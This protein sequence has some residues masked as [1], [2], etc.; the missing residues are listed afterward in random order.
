MS[1]TKIFSGGVSS[2]HEEAD[3]RMLLHAIHADKVFAEFGVKG[4]P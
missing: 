2:T 3:T 4:R 1:V